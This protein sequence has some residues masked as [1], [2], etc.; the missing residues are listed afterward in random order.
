[1]SRPTPNENDRGAI[2]TPGDTAA[3]KPIQPVGTSPAALDEKDEAR[4]TYKPRPCMGKGYAEYR[5]KAIA[6]FFPEG[7][8]VSELRNHGEF[9]GKGPEE[10]FVM[11]DLWKFDVTWEKTGS[12]FTSSSKP[13]SLR[14]SKEELNVVFLEALQAVTKMVYDHALINL[15]EGELR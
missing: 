9:R 15:P 13:F 4:N 11:T 5:I 14:I 1:M 3:V 12:G 8:V 2:V 6:R 7:L 10:K